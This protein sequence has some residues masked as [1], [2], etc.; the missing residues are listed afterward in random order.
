MKSL[1]LL[2]AA[3]LTDDNGNI[4]RDSTF[5]I[6]VNGQELATSYADGTYTA[7][8][9]IV[10][11]GDNIVSTSYEGA[12]ITE[13]KYVVE[14]ENATLTVT[15]ENIIDGEAATVSVTLTGINDS[16]LS[17]DVKVIINNTEYIIPVSRKTRKGNY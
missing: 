6:T 10:T 8:Y 11:A 16:P 5:K 17:G 7:T 1:Q 9:T 13:G 15:V 3:T 14:K 12:T 4:I 2:Y